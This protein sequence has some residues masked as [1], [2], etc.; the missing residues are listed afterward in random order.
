MRELS[1]SREKKE[2]GEEEGKKQ[3]DFKGLKKPRRRAK[4]LFESH[5]SHRVCPQTKSVCVFINLNTHTKVHK[6]RD[7][8][9]HN[10]AHKT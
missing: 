6:E 3:A 7:T 2:K 1:I 8:Y 9:T 10:T 5:S 4:I